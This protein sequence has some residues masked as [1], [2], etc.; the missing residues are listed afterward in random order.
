M[1]L[2]SGWW[3]DWCW[4]GTSEGR[5]SF[6]S[7]ADT[8]GGSRGAQASQNWEFLVAVLVTGL[9]ISLIIALLAKAQVVRRYIASYRHTRL[10][11]TDSVGQ[12]EPSGRFFGQAG[13][14]SDLGLKRESQQK[15]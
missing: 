12:C 9:S 13:R 4:D 1:F 7:L 10:V 5:D 8:L 3:L 2:V 14:D 15:S 11:E 6:P